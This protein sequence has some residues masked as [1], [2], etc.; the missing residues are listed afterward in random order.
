MLDRF[1]DP[2]KNLRL[3]FPL[4]SA[5]ESTRVRKGLNRPSR[6]RIG[7]TFPR[8]SR[9]ASRWFTVPPPPQA[10]EA[11]GRIAN[12]RQKDPPGRCRSSRACYTRRS[13]PDPRRSSI[14]QPSCQPLAQDPQSTALPQEHSPRRFCVRCQKIQLPTLSAEVPSARPHKW[15]G[16]AVESIRGQLLK[17]EFT[18]LTDTI[19]S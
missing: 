19:I 6:P 14:A 17:A 18:L 4:S 5:V 1:F 15:P 7:K 11:H 12:S 8:Q 2:W 3:M 9:S 16:G 10:S 13:C